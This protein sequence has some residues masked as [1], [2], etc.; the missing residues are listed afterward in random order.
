[1]INSFEISVDIF[2]ESEPGEARRLAARQVGVRRPFM[3]TPQFFT[4]TAACGQEGKDGIAS[5]FAA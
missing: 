3:F 4:M 5:T 2:H 1:M